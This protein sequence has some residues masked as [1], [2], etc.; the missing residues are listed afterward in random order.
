MSSKA[1]GRKQERDYTF[2]SCEG[3]P[4]Q[5]P[6]G[7]DSRQESLGSVC[8]PDSAASRQGSRRGGEEPAT[9][10]EDA[11]EWGCVPAT[12]ARRGWDMRA[13]VS[14][15]I[16]LYVPLL[17]R[18]QTHS[19]NSLAAGTPRRR[20]PRLFCLPSIWGMSGSGPSVT[21]AVE[22]LEAQAAGRSLVRKWALSAACLSPRSQAAAGRAFRSAVH[23]GL[24]SLA[25]PGLRL[26]RRPGRQL[27]YISLPPVRCREAARREAFAS[28][29]S[30]RWPRGEGGVSARAAAVAALERGFKLAGDAEMIQELCPTVG[31]CCPE[32]TTISRF[33]GNTDHGDS[34]VTSLHTP[35]L[36]PMCTVADWEALSPAPSGLWGEP[37]GHRLLHRARDLQRGE[38]PRPV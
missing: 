33:K 20:G 18:F 19:A 9:A 22:D 26:E 6:L 35:S 3:P 5:P 11:L 24:C 12:A 29:E 1:V 30:P 28:G 32:H 38:R 8:T 15:A 17:L 21:S 16:A 14:A 10:F 4:D 25:G 23:C 2:Q 7:R 31:L 37:V 36:V 13:A 27:D 34:G